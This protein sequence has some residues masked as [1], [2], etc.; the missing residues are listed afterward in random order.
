MVHTVATPEDLG[1]EVEALARK[2]ADG[3]PIAMRLAKVLMYRGIE[4]DRETAMHMAS[5]AEPA[6]LSSW[7]HLEGLAALSEK[8]APEFR[9]V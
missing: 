7:D 1:R 4:V 6:T 8:R 5:A 9:G 2:I 3:P